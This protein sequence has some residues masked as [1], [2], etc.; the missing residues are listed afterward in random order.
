M[1]RVAR[2]DGLL[3]NLRNPNGSPGAPG[4]DDLRAM[5]AWI[6]EHRTLTTPFDIV[7]EGETP[8]T[9]PDTA[10]AT[11]RP[12]AEAGATWWI[13]AWWGSPGGADRQP[14]LHERVRQGPPRVD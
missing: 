1:R 3:P 2:Y 7:V 6:A 13:E 4:P 5:V 9:D 12:W 10:A 14:A 8:G 11:V